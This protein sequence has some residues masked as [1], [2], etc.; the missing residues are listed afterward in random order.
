M[1]DK[2]I[3]GDDYTFPLSFTNLDGTPFN[4]T[5]CTVWFAA[6]PPGA[7]DSRAYFS[8]VIAFDSAGNVLRSEQYD[9]TST[10]DPTVLAPLALAAGHVAADGLLTQTITAATT[11]AMG[12]VAY[13]WEIQILDAV[14][15]VHT[16]SSG[17]GTVTAD[18]IRTTT[19]P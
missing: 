19:V 7:D 1:S 8:Q 13:N 6:V 17:S 11:A 5:G 2:L 16:P 15:K 12:A 14:G 3:R 9:N 10:V 18:I 4:L